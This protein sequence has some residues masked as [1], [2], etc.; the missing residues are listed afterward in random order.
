MKSMWQHKMLLISRMDVMEEL[1]TSFQPK[2]TTRQTKLTLNMDRELPVTR[3]INGE[4]DIKKKSCLKFI[5][6]KCMHCYYQ[7][8]KNNLQLCEFVINMKISLFYHIIFREYTIKRIKTLTSGEI[9]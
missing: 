7:K 9:H 1:N 8:S 5:H 2:I 4:L 3:M 6:M